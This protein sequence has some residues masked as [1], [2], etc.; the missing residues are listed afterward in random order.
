MQPK[1]RLLLSVPSV[2]IRP[3]PPKQDESE[4]EQNHRDRYDPEQCVETI[5]RGRQ[6]NRG[7]VP[8]SH[9]VDYFFI[10]QALSNCIR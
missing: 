9:Q 5:E 7:S 4:T 2:A 1:A 8:G 10:G 6:K 3:E